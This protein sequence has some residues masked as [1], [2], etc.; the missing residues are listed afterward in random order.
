[1]SR[2]QARSKRQSIKCTGVM[3]HRGYIT[4]LVKWQL[5]LTRTV[6]VKHQRAIERRL[7]AEGHIGVLIGDL[8]KP[9]ANSPTLSFGSSLMISDALTAK[10]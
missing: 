4:P 9:L 7:V 10:L 8:Q 5:R 2:S 6:C 3:P 1:M